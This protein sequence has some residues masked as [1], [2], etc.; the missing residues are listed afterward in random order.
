MICAAS[1]QGVKYEGAGLT[2]IGWKDVRTC[3]DQCRAVPP[4]RDVDISLVVH[5]EPGKL[6]GRLLEMLL[7]IIGILRARKLV[8]ED[9]IT[10][11]TKTELHNV[12]RDVRSEQVLRLSYLNRRQALSCSRADGVVR[13]FPYISTAS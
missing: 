2:H 3:C 8:K 6:D 5:Q 10:W 13:G 12:A 4:S 11:D 9:G 7:V 1:A